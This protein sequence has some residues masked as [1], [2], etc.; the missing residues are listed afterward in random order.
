[1]G[2]C[3]LLGFCQNLF[4]I[5]IYIFLQNGVL[6][7]IFIKTFCKNVWS[8]LW[9]FPWFFFALLNSFLYHFDFQFSNKNIHLSLFDIIDFFS[10]RFFKVNFFWHCLGF[11]FVQK[12]LLVFRFIFKILIKVHGFIIKILSIYWWSFG[13]WE[14]VHLSLGR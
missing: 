10:L 8:F 11:K 7:L 6:S 9:S 1:M 12:K 3:D 5:W 14:A 4:V 13:Y 2:P